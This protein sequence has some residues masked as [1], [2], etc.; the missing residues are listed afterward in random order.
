M[1][2]T[3]NLSNLFCRFLSSQL[4]GSVHD[5]TSNI[6]TGFRQTSALNFYLSQVNKIF[7]RI[8]L[9]LCTTLKK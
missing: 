9:K 4:S 2:L 6:V 3:S 1:A 5:E 7:E 8:L